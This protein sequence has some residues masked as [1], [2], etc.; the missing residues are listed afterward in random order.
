[1]LTDAKFFHV[2]I[3]C[4]DLA[5][6]RRFYTDG[7]GLTDGV[8]TRVDTAQPGDAFGLDEA[9]WDAWILVGP[10][11]FEGGAIDLLEWQTPPPDGSAPGALNEQGFQRIGVSV[12]DLDATLT[13]IAA[14]GG[15][16]WS[17]PKRHDLGGGRSVRLVMVNDPDGVAIELIEGRPSALSFVAVTCADLERS[18]AF[19][20]RLG[21]SIVARFRSGGDDGSHVHIVGSYA[22]DEIMLQAPAAGDVTLLLVE[23]SHPVLHPVAPRP[24]N[25]VGM[26]RAAFVVADLDAAYRAITEAGIAPI[27]PPMAMAMGEGLP[28]LRFFCFRGPDGESLELIEQP[29]SA[30]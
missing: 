6:S 26:W 1:M 29:V 30:A 14:A 25:A 18:R 4:T 12:P 17:A 27:S 20:E 22:M 28:E 7:L 21:F 13:A 3:N 15:A 23:F 24:A 5:R 16:A 8:R 11:A 10:R 2:N 19:Y 9:R